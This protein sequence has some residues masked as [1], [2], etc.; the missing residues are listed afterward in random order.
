M[1]L[2]TP[3]A[4]QMVERADRDNLPEDHAMRRIA[5][6]FD[7]TS[8]KFAEGKTTPQEMVGAWGRARRCWSNYTGEPLV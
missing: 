6:E 3:L 8:V 7:E 4:N 2:N 5:L 1:N